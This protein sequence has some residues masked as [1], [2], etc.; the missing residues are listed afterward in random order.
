MS[1]KDSLIIRLNDLDQ[2]TTL[3]EMK[4]QFEA[5]EDG[6]EAQRDD[7]YFSWDEREALFLGRNKDKVTGTT[8]S[9]INTQELQN[10]VFDGAS[11]VM[12]QVPTGHIQAMTKEDRGKNVMMNLIF[13]KYVKPNANAQFDL[14]TKFKLWDVYSKVYGSYP[15]L[16]D[17]RVDDDYTGPDLWLI[18]P[19]YFYPEKGATT[20]EEASRAFVD[21]YVPVSWLKDKLDSPNWMNVKKLL[22]EIEKAGNT[23][24]KE[25]RD[26]NNRTYA[27]KEYNRSA[28]SYNKGD[29]A[30]VLLRTRYERNKWTTYAPDYDIVVRCIKNPQKNNQIPIVVKECFPLLDRFYGLAEFERGKTLAYAMN[31]LVN[32]YMDGVKMSIFPP[33]ILREGGYVPSS[34]KYG[35]LEKWL[36][37][38]P[39]AIRQLQLSPLGLNTFQ[40]TYSYLKGA[41]LNMGATT[42]TSVSSEVDTGM[43]KTPQALRMQEGRMGA[44]DNWDRF[45][46]EKAIEKTF[47]FFVDSIS[48]RQEKPIDLTLLSKELTEIQAVSPDVVEMFESNKAGKVTIK[49]EEIKGAKYRFYIDA[50]TTMQKEDA[51]E[52]ATFEKIITTAM[53]IPSIAQ[54][55]QQ[56]ATQVQMGNKIFDFG[57]AFSK[58]IQTSGISEQ[59]KIIKDVEE[60]AGTEDE[61][62]PPPPQFEDPRINELA[63]FIYQSAGGQQSGNS[64]TAG[65]IDPMATIA[66]GQQGGFA[67]LS[68][69]TPTSQPY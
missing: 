54:Q 30:L 32:L 1:E 52:H 33:V 43:G 5:D 51:L 36:E 7:P 11:R 63:Q 25:S 46:M 6:V 22:G 47:N 44:R 61:I 19:R 62:L 49:P 64:N 35:A 12:A 37:K 17:Y 39:N 66:G 4:D 42:D 27:E 26:N 21:T 67:G 48:Q 41:L 24:G 15:A 23:K 57:E 3:E 45:M 53:S 10:L 55:L 56:G 8:K 69:A 38:E 20:I 34:I 40:S 9:Q 14:L 18:N 28:N 60:V 68:G 58:W 59:N 2:S 16:V 31:S 29:H 65:Q 13:E 50:G